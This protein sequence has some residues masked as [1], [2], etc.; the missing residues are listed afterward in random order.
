MNIR[1]SAVVLGLAAALPFSS[2]VLASEERTADTVMVTATRQ[3]S[4]VDELIADVSVVTREEIERLGD[5]TLT[6][7]LARTAGVFI[8]DGGLPGK[9]VSVMIRGADTGHALL[10]I[11]GMPVTSATLGRRRSS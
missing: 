10:L 7:I 4:K 2:V 3:E 6:Q 8:T 9:N 11:D 1:Y 5:T